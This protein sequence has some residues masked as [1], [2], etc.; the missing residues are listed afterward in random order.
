MRAATRHSAAALCHG[1]P[2]TPLTR[3]AGRGRNC[4]LQPVMRSRHSQTHPQADQSRDAGR[5]GLRGA[6]SGRRMGKSGRHGLEGH[7]GPARS[8]Q[9]LR[10]G[11]RRASI[12]PRR[13]AAPPPGGGALVPGRLNPPFSSSVLDPSCR[14]RVLLPFGYTGAVKK[15]NSS[16][17]RASR[18]PSSRCGAYG[19]R[20]GR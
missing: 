7:R 4:A 15:G 10:E 16:C 3:I 8:D 9:D 2:L 17:T 13:G 1:A 6:P 19:R 11:H 18:R 5:A 20:E 14:G 12:H